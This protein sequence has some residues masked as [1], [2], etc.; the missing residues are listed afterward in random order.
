MGKVKTPSDSY[1]KGWS[2]WTH[3]IWRQVYLQTSW[4]VF[5]PTYH[6]IAPTSL[7]DIP[8]GWS[9]IVDTAGLQECGDRGDHEECQPC[10]VMQTVYTKF[11]YNSINGFIILKTSLHYSV[12]MLY[13][14]IYKTRDFLNKTSR[15]FP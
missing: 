13:Q 14:P 12:F 6:T 10:K 15:S 3:L 4:A 2:D 11:T 5:P 7:L 8:Q 9:G 1:F